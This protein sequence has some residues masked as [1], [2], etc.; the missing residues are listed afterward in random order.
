M[1]EMQDSVMKPAKAMTLGEFVDA[2]Q[3]LAEAMLEESEADATPKTWDEWMEELNAA[4][5]AE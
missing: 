2:V 5:F 3:N 4:H 1:D